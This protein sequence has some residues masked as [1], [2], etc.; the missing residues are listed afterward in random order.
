MPQDHANDRGGQTRRQFIKKTGAATAA[1]AGAGLLNL[2]ISARAQPAVAA[3][4]LDGA[5][6]L[7]KTAP[8]QW[9]SQQLMAALVGRGF[10][11]EVQLSLEAVSSAQVC[12]LAGG[13]ASI[14]ARALLDAAGLSLPDAPECVA[15]A[16]GKAQGRSAL[17]AAGSDERGLVYALLE[18]ADRVNFA[19]NPL[20]ALDAKAVKPVSERPA[21]AIRSVSRA[22]VSDVEDKPW[23][24]DRDFWP[25]YLTMLAAQRFNRFNL[26]LGIGYDFTTDIRDCY[27]HFAYPFLL[28]VPGYH[29]R[30]TPLPDAERDRNLDMLRFISDECARRGL[31]FQLGLWT[32]AYQWTRSPNAN[33][34]IEGL[35]PET[36]APYCR[37]ALR[38]LLAACPA[39]SGVTIRIHGE[40]GVPEGNYGL[41]KTIFDGVATCGR[42]VEIDMHAK[43]MDQGMMD[44][45]LGTGR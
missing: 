25:P 9:A 45:A 21:N 13:R 43:G 33:Y 31:H 27:L 1:V 10:Q 42:R 12:V 38:A 4:V 30:A 29:V 28:D 35:T 23:F 24:Q 7:T 32:H 16:G 8:V 2:P 5:D 18:V 39:I 6:P 14:P 37:D 40:S 15:L 19:D 22:F 44:V 34:T 41:W 20:A 36:H 17:L 26:A 11:V 3:V